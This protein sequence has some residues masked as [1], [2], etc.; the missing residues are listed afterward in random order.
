[1]KN[2]F[3]RCPHCK[4]DRTGLWV[5]KCENCGRIMCYDSDL[6]GFT[7]YGC[8]KSKDSLCLDCASPRKKEGREIIKAI[9]I[10]SKDN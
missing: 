10:V 9:G 8:W 5:Y 6:L 1:M 7:K 4:R 2:E 3:S